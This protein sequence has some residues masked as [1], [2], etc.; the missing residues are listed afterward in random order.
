MGDFD[1]RKKFGAKRFSGGFGG[2]SD[3]GP[4][5]MHRATCSDC[6]NECEVP[7]K[8]NGM[9]PVYC[10]NCFKKEED[11]GSH[12]FERGGFKKFDRRDERPSFSDRPSFQSRGEDRPM[13]EAT[14]ADCGKRCEVP[15]RPTGDK[16]VFCRDCF[17]ANKN[18][19]F[20][21]KKPRQSNEQFER[22]IEK[23][24][25]IVKILETIQGKKSF[26]VGKPENE[27][28]NEPKIEKEERVMKFE[29]PKKPEI[30]AAKAKKAVKATKPKKEKKVNPL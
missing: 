8:P 17:G 6:G 9:K 29:E 3:R 5:M 4:A 12:G 30:V 23:L 22:L 21:L 16:P 11:S 10:N 19:N 25:K 13:H 15:F 26:V 2:R 18:E 14:C 7:F 1:K 20:D 27:L 24:D 28:K